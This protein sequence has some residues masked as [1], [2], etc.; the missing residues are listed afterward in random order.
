MLIMKVALLSCAFYLCAAV[1]AE[2][3]FFGAAYFGKDIIV[4]GTW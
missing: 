2:L 3:V 1:I 4:G